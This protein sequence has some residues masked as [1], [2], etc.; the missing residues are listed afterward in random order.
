[1]KT[2]PFVAASLAA[3]L[4]PVAPAAAALPDVTAQY[5]DGLTYTLGWTQQDGMH[6]SLS[7]SGLPDGLSFTATGTTPGPSRGSPSRLRTTTRSS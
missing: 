4:L 3:L 6:V 2:R 1:M 7:V 5:S